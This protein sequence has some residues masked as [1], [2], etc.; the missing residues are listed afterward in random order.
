MGT[1]FLIFCVFNV[2][3]WSHK[4]DTDLG[5][6]TV[7]ALAPLPIGLA[8]CVSHL[9]LGPFTGCG[10]NP[11]RVLGAVVWEENFWDGRAGKHF[12]IYMIGPCIASFI[13]PLIYKFFF[14]TFKPGSE[15]PNMKSSKTLPIDV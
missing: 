1:A 7:S 6:T 4:S 3:V 11:A 2:A 15:S 14:G 5:S 13:G 12:Y 10:I 8:V 9:T